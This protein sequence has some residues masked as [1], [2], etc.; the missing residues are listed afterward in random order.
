[1]Y[2]LPRQTGLPHNMPTNE[3][4]GGP[5]PAVSPCMY[6]VSTHISRPGEDLSGDGGDGAAVDGVLAAGAVGDAVRLQEVLGRRRRG[7]RRSVAGSCRDAI[8]Y[9]L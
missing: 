5:R 7:R 8:Q 4:N 3:P 9:T 6:V 2:L 1:M